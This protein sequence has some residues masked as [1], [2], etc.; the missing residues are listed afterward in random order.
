MRE[1]ILHNN[2]ACALIDCGDVDAAIGLLNQALLVST[3]AAAAEKGTACTSKPKSALS[4]SATSATPAHHRIG[5]ANKPA[6][7]YPENEYDEGMTTF[8]Q[9]LFLNDPDAYQYS[10]TITSTI[11]FN[12]G[13]AHSRTDSNTTDEDGQNRKN[14][15]DLNKRS[16]SE[17]E[18]LSCFEA[19]LRLQLSMV[20]TFPTSSALTRSFNDILCGPALHVILHNIGRCHF[21]SKRYDDS[22]TSYTRALDFLMKDLPEAATNINSTSTADP[23]ATVDLHRLEISAT[24]N[25]IAVSKCYAGHDDTDNII[26]ILE[27]A[28]ALRLAASTDKSTSPEKKTSSSKFDRETATIIYNTGRVRYIRG[29]F[30]A[31]LFVYRKAC[32]QRLSI[33]GQLHIDV[34]AC[35]INMAQSFEYIGY[36]LEAIDFYKQFLNIALPKLGKYAEDVCRALLR[37]GQLSY[38]RRNFNEAHAF[39]V[40]G[41]QSTKGK[42]GPNHQTVANI[43]NKIGNLLF[44]MDMYDD[45]LSAYQSGLRLERAL[46]PHYHEQIAIT[47]LNIGRIYHGKCDLDQALQLYKDALDIRQHLNSDETVSTILFN[48]GLIYETEN[49]L[50][51]AVSVLEQAVV[52]HKQLKE[53]KL[54]VSATLNALGHVHHKRGSLNLALSSFL[55]AIDIYNCCQECAMFDND[56]GDAGTDGASPLSSY[57]S[58]NIINLYFNV[59]TVY[60]TMGKTDKALHFFKESLRLEEQHVQDVVMFN[61]NSGGARQPRSHCP[62]TEQITII[63][64]E[65]GIILKNRGDLHDAISHLKQSS[66]MCLGLGIDISNARTL[67]LSRYRGMVHRVFTTLGDL[68]I[69]IGDTDNA[70][71]SYAFVIGMDD[72]TETTTGGFDTSNLQHARSSSRIG[73]FFH[74]LLCK[75]NPPASAAA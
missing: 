37:V 1:V 51:E 5:I 62:N 57:S 40:Q 35:I 52:L 75:T 16:S 36:T 11:F 46:Y 66:Q 38:V 7:Y 24:L 54:L 2:E 28:L 12:L 17:V 41:L 6:H 22:I 30:E 56:S 45:A 25:C 61:D 64:C 21:R 4:P 26:I 47:L 59:A 19:S 3:S 48:I 42:L 33:L 49:K 15:H 27:K 20:N 32:G 67:H 74:M 13:I 10:P 39:L 73:D 31:A 68:Y 43:Y 50:E 60:K 34:A 63:H 53:E 44:E 14:N 58:N 72:A 70:I 29:E 71:K 23:N 55:E 18:A 8:A 9:P 65:I 69:E